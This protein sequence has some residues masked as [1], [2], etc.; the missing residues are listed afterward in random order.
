MSELAD[1]EVLG[2]MRGHTAGQMTYV[3]ANCV[4]AEHR[5]HN[6]SLS[7]ASV[8]RR[9]K[10]LEQRDVVERVHSVYARQICWRLKPQPALLPG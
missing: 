4:R 2:L 8:L 7:T 5:R 3:I 9:L 10:A 1:D 6:G